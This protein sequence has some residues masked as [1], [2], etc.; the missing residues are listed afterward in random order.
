MLDSDEEKRIARTY[1]PSN[2]SSNSSGGS[3]KIET[4]TDWLEQVGSGDLKSGNS[5]QYLAMLREWD[6][7]KIA[8]LGTQFRSLPDEKKRQAAEVIVGNGGYSGHLDPALV[9]DAIGFLVAQP[10][11]PKD[12]NR[13]D[14]F[15]P[16]KQASQFAVNWSKKDPDAASQW[17]QSLPAG[18]AKLWAQK[19]LAANWTQYD[20]EAVDQWIK[21]L[22]A[23]SRGEVEKFIKT[24]NTVDEPEP[25]G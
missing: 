21:T 8:E 14:S 19:N 25:E 9:S 2:R 20:P 17:V 5:Y 11:A 13:S 3:L 12:G 15:D 1:L 7:D 16:V 24:H 6:S 23:D 22:P 10:A 4:P 18:D